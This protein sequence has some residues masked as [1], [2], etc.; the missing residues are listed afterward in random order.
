MSYQDLTQDIDRLSEILP[1]ND[2]RSIN[3][4]SKTSQDPCASEARNVLESFPHPLSHHL[5]VSTHGVDFVRYPRIELQ[6]K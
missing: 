2:F 3:H 4:R 5:F 1:Q 6:A